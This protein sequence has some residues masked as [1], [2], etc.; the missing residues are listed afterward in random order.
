LTQRQLSSEDESV[1]RAAALLAEALYE[2]HRSSDRDDVDVARKELTATRIALESVAMRLE[3]QME[4]EKEHRLLL[5][6]QLSNLAVSLE[7][8]VDHLQRLSEMVGTVFDRAAAA[9]EAAATSAMAEPAFLPG[10]EGVSV[11][12][13]GVPGFQALMDIQ[14]A[15]MSIEAVAGASVERFQEGDSRILLH[16]RTP[17]TASELANALRAATPY[18]F[19]VEE[20]RPELLS[21]RL[22]IIPA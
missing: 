22:K 17:V 1:R 21:L 2:L 16:L 8:L 19:A 9:P 12:V 10:G 5:A 6:G 14:K 13:L 18:A 20:A 11:A 4:E 15:L 7:H 3:R